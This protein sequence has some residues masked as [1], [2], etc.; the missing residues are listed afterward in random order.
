MAQECE[1]L[2]SCGFFK[3]FGSTK[4]L[5]CKGF[6]SQYCKGPMQGQCK[7]KE[8]RRKNGTPPADN[9][10]PSGAIMKV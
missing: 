7:R 8:Y 9:M 5:A 6:I 10:M 2:G 1:L 4:E 3:K